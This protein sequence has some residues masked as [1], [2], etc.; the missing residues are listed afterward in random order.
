M[1]LTATVHGLRAVCRLTSVF[2]VFNL[3]DDP[4]HTDPGVGIIKQLSSPMNITVGH[5]SSHTIRICVHNPLPLVLLKLTS[6]PESC[7]MKNQKGGSQ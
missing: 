1:V 3:P 5:I 4:K 2:L 6:S 7:A